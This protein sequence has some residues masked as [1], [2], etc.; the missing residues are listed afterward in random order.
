[1]QLAELLGFVI[2]DGRSQSTK[3]AKCVIACHVARERQVCPC[4]PSGWGGVGSV[5]QRAKWLGRCSKAPS[6]PRRAM[7]LGR[8]RGAPSVPQ[9]AMWLGRCRG[10]PSEPQRICKMTF[11]AFIWYTDYARSVQRMIK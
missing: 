10:A 6:V 8:C 5:P 3:T 2:S 4:V 7:W 1:M 11:A 9:R